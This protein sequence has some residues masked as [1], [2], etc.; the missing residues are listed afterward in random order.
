MFLL[1]HLLNNINVPVEVKCSKKKPLKIDLE[2]F[3]KSTGK[4]SKNCQ[5]ANQSKE[6]KL[7]RVHWLKSS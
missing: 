1:E 5:W 2:V 6:G 7:S 4:E 3:M